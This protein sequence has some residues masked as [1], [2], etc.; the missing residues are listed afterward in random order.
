MYTQQLK[1][2]SQKTLLSV[3]NRA[4]VWFLLMP[5]AYFSC[6]EV[7][8]LNGT[9]I[10]HSPRGRCLSIL[11]SVNA[12]GE[13]AYLWDQGPKMLVWASESFLKKASEVCP[14]TALSVLLSAHFYITWPLSFPSR[15]YSALLLCNEPP[16]MEW[17]VRLQWPCLTSFALELRLQVVS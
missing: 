15:L 11:V 2:S 5:H 14:S 16:K 9:S 1:F 4:M 10:L 8:G 12:C 7:L 3:Q 17:L 6:L 13:G